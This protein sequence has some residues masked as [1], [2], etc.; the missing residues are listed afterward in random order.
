MKILITSAPDRHC[1]SFKPIR[2]FRAGV[3]AER[4]LLRGP[5]RPQVGSLRSHRGSVFCI[6]ALP[7]KRDARGLRLPIVLMQCRSWPAQSTCKLSIT[8]SIF[9]SSRRRARSSAKYSGLS[10]R[11]NCKRT[12]VAFS[13]FRPGPSRLATAQV[14]TGARLLTVFALSCGRQSS[15]KYRRLGVG[16]YLSGGTDS[17][18]V[19]GMLGA[20]NSGPSSYVFDWV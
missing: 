6:S 7:C 17:S 1:S 9:M 5:Y 8:I 13:T 19:A 10:Q 3:M 14:S 15:A 20:D 11:P 18:T 4:S 16:A 12:T 2:L